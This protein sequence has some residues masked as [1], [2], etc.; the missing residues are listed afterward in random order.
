MYV[1]PEHVPICSLLKNERH[2]CDS[3][4]T[5]FNKDAGSTHTPIE[6]AELNYTSRSKTNAGLSACMLKVWTL[7]KRSTSQMRVS[8]WISNKS[9]AV[10]IL[11]HNEHVCPQREFF[12]ACWYE[13]NRHLEYWSIATSRLRLEFPDQNIKYQNIIIRC[14]KSEYQFGPAPAI[15][16]KGPPRFV[17]E[18]VDAQLT[19][20][21]EKNVF[22]S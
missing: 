14:N 6:L 11:S 1:T 16:C 12:I 13:D 9:Q 7:P 22:F 3:T 21:W 15:W 17:T 8:V 5:M 10:L 19:V 4:A 2:K 18:Q 20:L